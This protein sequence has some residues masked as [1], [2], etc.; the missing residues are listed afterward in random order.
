[1]KVF[2]SGILAA[3]AAG[4]AGL[5]AP[6]AGADVV[7][8]FGPGGVGGPTIDS[9]LAALGIPVDAS[10]ETTAT[11]FMVPGSGAVPLTF[12]AQFDE[13]SFLYDFGFY[14]VSK[15]TADPIADT[16]NY[17]IQALSNSVEIFNNPTTSPGDTKTIMV[18][19]GTVLGFFIVPNNTIA[20]FLAD[21]DSFYPP[22]TNDDS[23]RAPLF[24][25]TDANPGQFDQFLSFLGGGKTLFTFE[26][27]S[28][29][30]GSDDSFTDLGFSIDTQLV[31]PVAV[32][33]PSTLALAGICGLAGLVAVAR[34][35]KAI[36]A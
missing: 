28:R 17:A 32:P 2:R 26:D 22:S 12:T 34:R 20:N 30:D 24:S 14:D 9:T 19:G 8:H 29:A 16:K 3:L 11:T 36:A 5:M 23:L 27:L 35:R 1:M 15:V 31:T 25:V 33:E 21:P 10:S 18:G 4:M 7:T 13:G 6:S